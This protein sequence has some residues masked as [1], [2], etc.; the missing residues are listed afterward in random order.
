MHVSVN[1]YAYTC[2][3]PVQTLCSMTITPLG[4]LYVFPK[5]FHR[6]APGIRY[7]GILFYW[8]GL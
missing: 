2:D 4:L 8:G 1:V 7:Q 5:S 3:V 6:Y